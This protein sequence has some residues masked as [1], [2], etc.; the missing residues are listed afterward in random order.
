MEI[1]NE[2]DSL[3]GDIK[4]IESQFKEAEWEY[5]VKLQTVKYLENERKLLF[6]EFH[7]IV[8]EFH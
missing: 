2:L 4:G 5:E 8:Y 3:Q 7:R 6:D 1:K